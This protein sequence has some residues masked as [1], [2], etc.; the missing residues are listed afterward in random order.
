[1]DKN[2]SNYTSDP[3]SAVTAYISQSKALFDSNLRAFRKSI[4]SLLPLVKQTSTTYEVFEHDVPGA[5]KDTNI[6]AIQTQQCIYGYHGQ[7][8]VT[9]QFN[10]FVDNLSEFQ[11]PEQNLD[12]AQ[13]NDVCII[14]GLGA[15]W[16]LEHILKSAKF[17]YI[18]VYDTQ[19]DMLNISAQILDW[20]NIFQLAEEQQTQLFLQIPNA[21]QNIQ[22][23]LTELRQQCVVGNIF[24]YQ[25]FNDRVFCDFVANALQHKPISN[26]VDMS[27]YPKYSAGDRDTLELLSASNAQFKDNIA[28]FANE[29]PSIAQT[30]HNYTSKQ[31]TPCLIDGEYNLIDQSTQ[32][33]LFD[34]MHAKS[35]E[36]NV[37]HF[38][39]QPHK[40]ELIINIKSIKHIHYLHHQMNQ[41]IARLIDGESTEK[42]IL[43]KEIE[44]FVVYGM[45]VGFCFEALIQQLTIKNLIICESELDFFYAS[46]FIVDWTDI[47]HR[48]KQDDG[49]IYFNI[50]DNGQH[51]INDFNLQF[52]KI[53]QHNLAQTY[54]YKPYPNMH[55][56][57][58]FSELRDSLRTALILGENAD[59]ALHCIAHTQEGIVRDLPMLAVTETHT[60]THKDT[61]VFI[62][63]NGPSLDDAIAD[64]RD[65]A[66]NAIIISCGTAL[67]ALL[68]YGIKPD[69]HAE[70]EANFASYCW[71]VRNTTAEQRAGIH[72]ISCNGVHPDT[73]DLFDSSY[74]AVKAGESSSH[75]FFKD[76][77]QLRTLNHSYPTVSNFVLSFVLASGFENV[78]LHGVDFGFISKENHH[79]KQSAYYSNGQQTTSFVA[80][81]KETFTVP[82]NFVK[83]VETKFE[84]KLAVDTMRNLLKAY[85]GIEVYNT[86][87]GALIPGAFPLHPD[88]LMI[89][90]SDKKSIVREFFASQFVKPS[91]LDISAK[92]DT[93]LSAKLLQKFIVQL[94]LCFPSMSSFIEDLRAKQATI[95]HDESIA[96]YCLNGTLNSF[97]AYL[98]KHP[99]VYEDANML[100]TLVDVWNAFINELTARIEAEEGLPFDTTCAYPG[101]VAQKLLAEYYADASHHLQVVCLDI[102]VAA[103][104]QD[105]VKFYTLE[106]TVT[107]CSDAALLQKELKTLFVVTK[108]TKEICA[109]LS[110]QCT[111]E[112]A[113]LYYQDSSVN[114]EGEYKTRILVPE[115]SVFTAEDTNRLLMKTLMLVAHPTIA[116]WVMVKASYQTELTD[117]VLP[118]IP[119]Y[120]DEYRYD[121]YWFLFISSKMLPRDQQKLYSGLRLQRVFRPFTKDDLRL[122]DYTKK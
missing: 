114:T 120:L 28:S 19:S 79:S 6:F 68:N 104:L 71:I 14:L 121:T 42:S 47:L 94:P 2:L 118:C 23:D 29:I 33:L 15:G 65:N 22:D 10:H 88:L 78:Y 69:I 46:L 54:F 115:K 107:V 63:G 27:F 37:Q 34:Y 61:P 87:N 13:G 21:A 7:Q 76:Y 95:V 11:L 75:Y 106:H 17:K 109:Q 4:P 56:D 64:I 16:H 80:E 112:N 102:S 66:D 38:I 55:L 1:M 101:F 8:S 117:L 119:T 41:K 60:H 50:G 99:Y 96:L 77:P 116:D 24:V 32:V 35:R 49:H 30:Y 91:A 3:I 90:H 20:S 74:I 52:H 82:G 122:P 5:I 84:F 67:S 72:F 44:S 48:C 105:L 18:V 70:V 92:I 103:V 12:V 89:P 40:D 108:N 98:L 43:P 113:V 36:L 100:A 93:H 25:H 111:E 39:A 58:I 73:V 81:N 97:L 51:L 57:G 31:W 45:E 53:G 83:Q 62:I 9:L 26:T 59:Y 86:S 110:A 85:K